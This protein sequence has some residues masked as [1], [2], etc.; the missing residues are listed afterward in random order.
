[1]QTLDKLL[2]SGAFRLIQYGEI[3]SRKTTRAATALR[4][5]PVKF[6]DLDGKVSVLRNTLNPEQL[7]QVQVSSYEPGPESFGRLVAELKADKAA[8]ASNPPFATVV[9]DTWTNLYKLLHHQVIFQNPDGK[10]DKIKVSDDIS[11]QVPHMRDWGHVK[12][13]QRYVMDLVRDLP[14]NIIIN[15]HV[16]TSRD[17]T[18]SD[19]HTVGTTG[20]FGREMPGEFPDTHYLFFDQLTKKPK[21]RGHTGGGFQANTTLPLDIIDAAGCLKTWDLSVFDD[22]AY[23]IES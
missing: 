8:F 14:C 4:F 9:L 11:I 10:R 22:I 1:M 13:L 3:G 6:Y 21:V 19:Y 15:A 23:R 18:G 5:G 17:A 2:K 7:E 12:T 20:S 16:G